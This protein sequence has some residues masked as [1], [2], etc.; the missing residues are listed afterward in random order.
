MFQIVKIA[1][2]SKNDILTLRAIATTYKARPADEVAA[3]LAAQ[4][5]QAQ[6]GFRKWPSQ[7]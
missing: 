1:K 5:S 3:E 6:G 4:Q 7:F 2:D